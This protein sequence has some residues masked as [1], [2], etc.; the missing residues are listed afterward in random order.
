[1]APGPLTTP[2]GTTPV[3][4]TSGYARARLAINNSSPHPFMQACLKI[5]TRGKVT[6]TRKFDFEICG[7]EKVKLKY[8][9]KIIYGVWKKN[10]YGSDQSSTSNQVF[11]K[12]ELYKNM[13]TVDSI[14]C[15]IVQWHLYT[16]SQYL[17]ANG[18]PKYSPFVN[19]YK[20]YNGAT[21]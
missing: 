10:D 9:H 18:K 16:K 19:P 7:T 17:D 6:M 13:F 11:F 12:P 15:P 3:V 20:S 14:R 1:M 4:G 21:M 2:I 5:I 8:L